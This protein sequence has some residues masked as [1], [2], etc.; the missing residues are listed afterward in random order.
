[1]AKLIKLE[2]QT[3]IPI[4]SVVPTVGEPGILAAAHRSI[5]YVDEVNLFDDHVMDVLLDSAAGD[6]RKRQ[7]EGLSK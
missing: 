5:P 4:P 6:R 2:F 7:Y 3:E 1:M